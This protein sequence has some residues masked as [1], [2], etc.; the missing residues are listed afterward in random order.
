MA[1]VSTDNISELLKISSY[2][3]SV[4]SVIKK[5]KTDKGIESN[6]KIRLFLDVGFKEET[7]EQKSKRIAK[8]SHAVISKGG[9]FHM[10]ETTKENVLWREH[11]SSV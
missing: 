1:H 5:N 10:E 8:V 2:I 7:S 4:L 11:V 9:L 6:G 3:M